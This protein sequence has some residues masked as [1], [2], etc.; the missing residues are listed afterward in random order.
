MLVL[1]ENPEQVVA[2]AS[3]RDHLVV[4]HF[5][6]WV[7]EEPCGRR[8][9]PEAAFRRQR[10]PLPRGQVYPQACS[11][12]PR[13][14]FPPP[15]PPPLLVLG[16]ANPGRSRHEARPFLLEFVLKS[17]EPEGHVSPVLAGGHKRAAR[18]GQ[19]PASGTAAS[20]VVAMPVERLVVSR[21]GPTPAG[22]KPGPGAAA[23]KRG[24]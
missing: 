23:I 6:R 15:R 14:A 13:G 20:F 21:P 5:P 16:K 2:G 1:L 19:R 12:P 17:R 18:G 9:R 10:Y 3:G 7:G 8:Q 4:R 24:D 22:L 11:Q